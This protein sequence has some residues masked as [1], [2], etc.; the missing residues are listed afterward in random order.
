V[1]HL[2]DRNAPWQAFEAYNALAMELG[3][4]MARGMPPGRVASLR[5]RLREVGG[6]DGWQEALNMVRQSEFITS[7]AWA[8]FGLHSMLQPETLARILE[9]TYTQRFKSDRETAREAQQAGL[10]ELDRQLEEFMASK[11]HRG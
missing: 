11:E 1:V 4:R 3:L 5:A 10:D 7:H 6:L 9:G 8:S 2:P